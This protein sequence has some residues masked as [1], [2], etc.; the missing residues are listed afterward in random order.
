MDVPAVTLAWIIEQTALCLATVEDTSSV[1]TG[2]LSA[3]RRS[4]RAAAASVVSDPTALA[5]TAGWRSS[6][7]RTPG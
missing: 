1:V 7:P 5:R 6:R 4:A 2:P 3:R